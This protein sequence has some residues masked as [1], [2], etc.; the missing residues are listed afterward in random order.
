MLVRKLALGILVITLV[1]APVGN[2]QADSQRGDNHKPNR[3]QS[4]DSSL[5]TAFGE[6][7]PHT[8]WVD[9]ETH[10]IIVDAYSDR[11]VISQKGRPPLTI[12]GLWKGR[13]FLRQTDLETTLGYFSVAHEGT[14]ASFFGDPR[15]QRFTFKRVR[16]DPK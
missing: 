9:V 8:R 11:L 5:A 10:S 2:I 3:K 7:Y 16:P 14:L 15:F 12:A 4:S 6:Y 1:G 13:A